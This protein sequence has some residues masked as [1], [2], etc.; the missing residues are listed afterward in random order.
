M[1]AL[2]ARPLRHYSKNWLDAMQLAVKNPGI[3][4]WMLDVR[5]D[6]L[7]CGEDVAG[8]VRKKSKGPAM[9]RGMLTV[10]TVRRMVVELNESFRREPGVLPE[11]TQALKEKRLQCRKVESP[12]SPS[13][14]AI[15]AYCIKP[16]TS[17]LDLYSG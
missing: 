4:Y 10:A 1:P 11:V 13:G 6:K 16:R 5:R 8:L 12:D 17:L 2:E 9:P 7:H 15:H 14:I 3:G